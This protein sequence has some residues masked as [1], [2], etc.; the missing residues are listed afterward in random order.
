MAGALSF[1][2][3]TTGAGG[4][5]KAP[6]AETPFRIAVLADL[7]GRSNRR[8]AGTPLEQRKPRKVTHETLEDVL[9]KL[10]PRLV[11]PI[12][13]SKDT[14]DLTFTTLDDFHPDQIFEKVEPLQDLS[15][16]EDQS[17]LMAQLMHHADF[18]GLEGTWRGLEWLLRRVEKQGVR[19][20]V[21]LYDVTFA[22]L[23]S[24]VN[25]ADDLAKCPLLRILL[26]QVSGQ[27]GEPWGLLVGLYTFDIRRPQAQV[28]GRLAKIAK[29]LAAPFL[30]GTHSRLL[31]PKLELE[32]E[33]QDAWDQ[34]RKVPETAFL[35]LAAPRFLLRQPYGENTKSI[36]RFR[37]EEF[38]VDGKKGLLW[39]NPALGCACLIGQTFIKQGWGLKPGGILDVDGLAM[40]VSR[41]E[42]DEEEVTVGE[43]WIHR[44]LAEKLVKLGLM[45]FLSVR[46]KNA[47]QLFKFLSLGAT[48]EKP[49]VGR[50]RRQMGPENRR[51]ATT[52]ATARRD[53]RGPNEQWCGAAAT[54]RGSRRP[55][56][57][58]TPASEA[59]P[60]A[61]PEP[62]AD[63]ALDPELAALQAQL[64]SPP[65]AAPPQP[66]EPEPPAEEPMD[67][68][69]AALLAQLEQPAEPPAEPPP[70][71]PPAADTDADAELAA[72]LAQLEQDAAPAAPPAPKP[73]PAAP[74]PT[75]DADAELAALLAQLEQDAAPPA[76][77]P[78]AS[79]EPVAS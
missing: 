29:R 52:A 73:I 53:G 3:L 46:G 15:D 78:P 17:K 6:S 68:E 7:C 16:D 44:P 40:H 69:L 30:A 5:E 25:V 41:N 31:D 4:D 2:S 66:A 37:Y 34:I 47:L 48:A 27:R 22:E 42:D 79:P 77:P 62:S 74:E 32:E 55:A 18:Q 61:A 50:S 23:T 8:D 28:L 45:P 20:E 75:D 63:E 59:P 19:L 64:E 33:D 72:L 39:G 43:A 24:A 13:K 71:E 76:E 9:A 14:A 26:E 49:A 57:R 70:P 56:S 51:R 60:A 35:G 1:G 58:E 11:L 65:A 21:L 36:D 67:P 12:P 54:C 10:Q 38:A